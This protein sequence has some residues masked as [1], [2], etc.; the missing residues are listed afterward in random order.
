MKRLPRNIKNY[1]RENPWLAPLIVLS[2]FFRIFIIQTVP[3]IWEDSYNYILYADRARLKGFGGFWF[4][5]TQ[6][7]LFVGIYYVLHLIL[8]HAYLT[9]KLISFIASLITLILAYRLLERRASKRAAIFSALFLGMV[10]VTYNIFT[11]AILSGPL[12]ALLIFLAFYYCYE[13]KGFLFGLALGAAF[14]TRH[15]TIV[16]A[17]ALYVILLMHRRWKPLFRSL[18]V[19]A[20]V[21]LIWKI[22]LL[23]GT[24]KSGIRE[25]FIERYGPIKG[26]W[27]LW[28]YIR[29]GFYRISI[30][31]SGFAN[32]VSLIV[33][34][35]AIASLIIGISRLYRGRKRDVSLSIDAFV[36]IFINLGVLVLMK[37]LRL[38]P[39]HTRH[40]VY[41]FPF[42]VVIVS[43]SID[44]ILTILQEK[45]SERNYRFLKIP[46]YLVFPMVMAAHFLV[47]NHEE[48]F[49]D[50][51]YSCY[52][53]YK[54]RKIA[55]RKAGEKLKELRKEGEKVLY[56]LPSLYRFAD[57]NMQNS[58]FF[59]PRNPFDYEWFQ[60]KDVTWAVW[61]NLRVSMNELPAT[62]EKGEDYFFYKHVY[63]PERR[64]LYPIIYRINE[65]YE[66]GT[67]YANLIPNKGWD[68]ISDREFYLESSADMII[69]GN[70]KPYYI[71][72][73][74][75]K[76]REKD[77]VLKISY[78]SYEF[79]AFRVSSDSFR[80]I[81]IFLSAIPGE[82][83]LIFRSGKEE[84][85]P[86]LI[87]RDIKLEPSDN[88]GITW[89]YGEGWWGQ[90]PSGRWMKQNS[91]IIIENAEQRDAILSFFTR[92]LQKKRTMKITLNGETM[93]RYESPGEQYYKYKLPLS[94][95]EG[96]HNLILS[97]PQ[98]GTVPAEA[99][100]WQ[101][102]RNVT[103]F[104]MKFR[105]QPLYFDEGLQPDPPLEET[106]NV[107]Y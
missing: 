69:V 53:H 50:P 42:T 52:S 3:D 106:V 39:F 90:E 15:E 14:I 51:E 48:R 82:N 70:P 40:L 1:L 6:H 8:N 80:K 28:E 93:T 87:V 55:S 98:E 64:G 9:G 91:D 29:E 35:I 74:E 76:A 31:F 92:S 32:V 102:T 79:A 23:S 20:P 16:A 99:G 27:Q 25:V 26:V 30:L 2:I 84:D 68:K 104:I 77:R 41:L 81:R 34:L 65:N 49:Y 85:V 47:T 24:S 94:L 63:T 56:T 4:G 62:L 33:A 12:F 46:V 103:F 38:H 21:M 105:I 59:W 86:T 36:F 43:L 73:F 22:F 13:G 10:C 88:P 97:T 19:V 78:P 101:D 57:L 100:L 107:G 66:G 11:V 95:Q 61:T 54:Y 45:T 71:L 75:V 37:Y 83:I 60:K 7:F 67:K 17:F 96:N 72:E 18:V 89:N 5:K 44:H 58:V